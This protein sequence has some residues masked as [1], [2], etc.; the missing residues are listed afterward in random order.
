MNYEQDR[1][2][3]RIAGLPRPKHAP[4]GLRAGQSRTLMLLS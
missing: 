4:L 1:V 3:V 2:V